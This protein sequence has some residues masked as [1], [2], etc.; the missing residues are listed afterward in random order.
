MTY[1]VPDPQVLDALDNKIVNHKFRLKVT[2]NKNETTENMGNKVIYIDYDDTKIEDITRELS[3]YESSFLSCGHTYQI[4]LNAISNTELVLDS[5][6][7]VESFL[8]ATKWSTFKFFRSRPLGHDQVFLI[9]LFPLEFYKDENLRI[10]I[11]D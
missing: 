2:G 10:E 6:A 9:A 8:A 5:E 4:I 1:Q 11:M 7:A 3:K